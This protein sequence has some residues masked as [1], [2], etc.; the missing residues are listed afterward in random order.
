MGTPLFCIL[1]PSDGDRGRVRAEFRANCNLATGALVRIAPGDPDGDLAFALGC[2]EPNTP[3][4]IAILPTDLAMAPAD[5]VDAVAAA[6][7]QVEAAGCVVHGARMTW[8]IESVNPCGCALGFAG[9]FAATGLTQTQ[10]LAE[11]TEAATLFDQM[12]P[13]FSVV[14]L[15]PFQPGNAD[16]WPDGLAEATRTAARNVLGN[17]C[18]CGQLAFPDGYARGSTLL[19]M[20]PLFGQQKVGAQWADGIGPATRLG[21]LWLEGH[22]N[23][24]PAAAPAGN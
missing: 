11:V 22:V 23:G 24:A 9:G 16:Q 13:M 5:Y 8:R 10:W 3:V 4:H 19:S 6:F 21:L 12:L 7:A 17:A 15:P 20:P 18:V 14:S 1:A 2:L